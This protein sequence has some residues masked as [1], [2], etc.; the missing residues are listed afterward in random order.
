MIQ[1]FSNSLL[2]LIGSCTPTRCPRD[3]PAFGIGCH[4]IHRRNLFDRH[5]AATGK[6]DCLQQQSTNGTTTIRWWQYLS[7]PTW[8]RPTKNIRKK[9]FITKRN[10]AG[11]R[12]A[13]TTLS[14]QPFVEHTFR[15]K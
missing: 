11:R 5:K 10:A 1:L 13:A 14:Q 6:C 2:I 3:W 15:I 7:L 12:I 8:R 9:E 4:N